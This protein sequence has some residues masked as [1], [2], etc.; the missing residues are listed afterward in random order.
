MGCA[1]CRGYEL[2]GNLY[3]DTNGNGA[4]DDGDT[5]WNNRDSW[6]P[7]GTDEDRYQAEFH[8]NGHTIS[9]L[10]INRNRREAN[11]MGLFGGLAAGGAVHHLGL[12]NADVSGDTNI[13]ALAGI[14]RGSIYA[15][16]TTGEVSAESY[17]GGIVGWNHGTVS[18]VWSDARVSAQNTAGGIVGPDDALSAGAA[19]TVTAS[20]FRGNVRASWGLNP[21]YASYERGLNS[22]SLHFGGAVG[23]A[24]ANQGP[25]SGTVSH[26]YYSSEH[27]SQKRGGE[28]RTAAELQAPTGCEDIYANWD[29][30][31]DGNADNP[32]E[33]GGADHWPSLRGVDEPPVSRPTR[34]IQLSLRGAQPLMVSLSNHVAISLRL[35][36]RRGTII[37]TATRLPPPYQVRGRNDMRKTERPGPAHD[38]RRQHVQIHLRRRVV[39]A[40]QPG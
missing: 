37:A 19:A 11:E 16:Y 35:S 27:T 5:Y 2:A 26:V 22:N 24:T 3:F 13:G 14:N 34:V 12:H 40:Q 25:V 32:W 1:P 6:R 21:T 20:Y 18:T 39:P 29:V 8:G 31:G 23:G 9:N 36:T 4:A 38:A 17:A 7:I 15:V 28:A 10:Y 30:D 33:F